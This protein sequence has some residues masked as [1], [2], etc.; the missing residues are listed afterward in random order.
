MFRTSFVKLLVPSIFI[1]PGMLRCVA[2]SITSFVSKDDSA[3]ETSGT[4]YPT[5][6]L[7]LWK[8]HVFSRRPLASIKL[9]FVESV[10][11]WIDNITFHKTRGACGSR[12]RGPISPYFWVVFRSPF[13]EQLIKFVFESTWF[14]P[15]P[16]LEWLHL[17]PT[18]CGFS[19]FHWHWVVFFIDY[20]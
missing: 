20:A 13:K 9:H 5:T 12:N 14:K 15:R 11:I 10:P 8:P 1:L 7:P 16:T 2:G 6:N 19:P 18:V 4:F 3:F 17:E